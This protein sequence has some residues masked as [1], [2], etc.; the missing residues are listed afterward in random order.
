MV[1][2]A[3]AARSIP[4]R[5]RAG[6]ASRPLSPPG[7]QTNPASLASL[8]TG[9][10]T[11]RASIAGVTTHTIVVHGMSCDHCASAVRS[12]IIKLPGVTTVEVDVAADT[13]QITATQVPGEAAL[14]AAVEEAGYEYAG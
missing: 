5:R 14:R 4:R 7:S 8:G 9:A 3:P 11:S 1:T 6:G 2:E 12:E 13:V 10:I